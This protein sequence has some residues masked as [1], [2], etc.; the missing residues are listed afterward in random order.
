MTR[1]RKCPTHRLPYPLQR[2]CRVLLAFHCT[3]KEKGSTC[4]CFWMCVCAQ[5]YPTLGSPMDCSPPDSSVHGISQVRILEWV[6]MSSSRGSS[7]P[8]IQPT[9]PESPVVVGGSLP[10][11]S[12]GS[13]KVKIYIQVNNWY[14]YFLTLL[15][16][17]H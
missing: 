6:A 14:Q 2:Y 10:L 11:S 9:S 16:F 1:L 5:S 3:C 13:P 17:S 15:L 8:R 4:L 7:W 12:L